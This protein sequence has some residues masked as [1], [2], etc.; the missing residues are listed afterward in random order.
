MVTTPVTLELVAMM[1]KL[2]E[3]HCQEVR[4]KGSVTL[5]ERLE[6]DRVTTGRVDKPSVRIRQLL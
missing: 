4:E 2:V 6:T 5:S 1:F 3:T